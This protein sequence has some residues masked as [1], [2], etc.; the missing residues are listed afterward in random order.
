[1]KYTNYLINGNFVNIDQLTKNKYL[2][3]VT[4]PVGIA[5]AFT[6]LIFL[7]GAIP[8]TVI[9]D[10]GRSL[11]YEFYRLVRKYYTHRYYENLFSSL[12]KPALNKIQLH[13]STT[14]SF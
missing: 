6:G 9:V 5:V 2:R 8:L 12:S 11:K 4:I 3:P 7:S 10:G 13:N 14:C 1:M